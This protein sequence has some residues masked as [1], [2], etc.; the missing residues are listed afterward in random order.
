MLPSRFISATVASLVTQDGPESMA[1]LIFF[2]S[3]V[4]VQRKLVAVIAPY[5]LW[6]T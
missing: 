2:S 6:A 1:R 4:A 3:R 5:T